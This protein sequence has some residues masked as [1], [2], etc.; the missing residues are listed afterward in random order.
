MPVSRTSM[1]T[2]AT[3]FDRI[4]HACA[5][6]DFAAL[7]ELDRVGQ[8]VEQYLAQ[9]VDIAQET[10]PMPP[11]SI[12]VL[13]ISPLYRAC[14]ST[15]LTASVSSL[16]RIERLGFHLDPPGLDL[17]RVEDFLDLRQRELRRRRQRL[18]DFALRFGQLRL[19][20]QVAHR[21]DAVQRRAHFVADVGEEP[22]FGG[23]R[24]V[25][26]PLGL[27]DPFRQ[28]A[29]VER[30]HHH[31][32]EEAAADPGVLRPEWRQ[33]HQHLRPRFSK[34]RSRSPSS[35]SSTCTRP[36]S[37]SSGC[38]G[39]STICSVRRKTRW[40]GSRSSDAAAAPCR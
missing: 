40:V 16:P 13:T 22:S 20:Q 30:Q 19:A 21:D 31:R 24:L 6:R 15:T 29:D 11:S 25:G 39:I 36:A 5:Q 2:S 3:P 32:H 35:F 9:V 18:D 27:R 7:G 38:G 1:R 4:G 23:I 26:A 17:G 10:K 28:L 8:Q 12:S 33:I 14:G 37:G 34:R